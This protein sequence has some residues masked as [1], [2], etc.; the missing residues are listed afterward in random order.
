M[1]KERLYLSTIDPN[2]HITA[3]RHG[4]G[5]EIAEFCT[6]WNMDE[7]FEKTDR[8]VEEKSRGIGRFHLHAPFNELFPCAVDRKARRLAAERY[9]QAIELAKRY[10]AAKV[11][12][13][14]GY[15][16]LLYYPQWY[17]SESVAFWKEFLAEQPGVEI[18]LENVMEETPEMLAQIIADVGSEN[19]RMCLDV[20]HANAYSKIPMA[21]WLECCAPWIS[22]FHIHN[23]DGS[24]DTHSP[25]EQGSIPLQELLARA[26]VLCPNATF[27]LELTEGEPAVER[28]LQWGELL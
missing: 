19:L 21:Q 12:I 9:R 17:H 8:L 4:L 3:A 26:D 23:N 10:G 15:H 24:W 16:P 6:A 25:L 22:H 11:I 5:L 1:K 27:T 2:A 18:V 7:E 20:G 13:H 28:L 14:G